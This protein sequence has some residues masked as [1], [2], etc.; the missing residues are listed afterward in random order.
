M[1]EVLAK[2]VKHLSVSKTEE[3][4]LSVAWEDLKGWNKRGKERQES[5]ERAEN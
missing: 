5:Q 4:I 1:F 3:I 2:N